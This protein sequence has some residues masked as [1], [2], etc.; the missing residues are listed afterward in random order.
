MLLAGPRSGG[1]DS[2]CDIGFPLR[3]LRPERP[4]RHRGAVSAPPVS[5]G[6]EPAHAGQAEDPAPGVRRN[7]PLVSLSFC[8]PSL[9]GIGGALL[10]V[11]DS[12]LVFLRFFV[13]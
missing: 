10:F 11:F 4:V 5:A 9:G 1:T 13:L 6:Q 7:L 8:S 12:L 2:D 3:R